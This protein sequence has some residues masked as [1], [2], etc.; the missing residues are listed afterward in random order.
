M[1]FPRVGQGLPPYGDFR[2]APPLKY[3]F[4]KSFLGPHGLSLHDLTQWLLRNARFCKGLKRRIIGFK[5][6]YLRTELDLII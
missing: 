6:N 2:W 5:T 3:G 1:K 4:L